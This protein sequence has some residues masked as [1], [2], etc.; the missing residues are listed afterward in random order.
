MILKLFGL[1][2]KFTP[3]FDDLGGIG[4]MI[5]TNDISKENY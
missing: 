4:K 5:V 3:Y 1:L 2:I